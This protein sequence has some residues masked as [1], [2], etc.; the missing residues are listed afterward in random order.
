MRQ[1]ALLVLLCWACD[2]G[3]SGD[4]GLDG[5]ATDGAGGA[6]DG[7]MDR[8]LDA[9]G[10]E[11]GNGGE[12][13]KDA[14]LTDER[15]PD[16]QA[17]AQI[18]VDAAEGPDPRLADPTAAA[19]ADLAAQSARPLEISARGGL[20]RVV[21]LD[22][23]APPLNEPMEAALQFLNDHLDIWQVGDA[24]E[25][26]Y[27][28]RDVPHGDGGHTFSFGQRIDNVPVHLAQIMVDIKDGRI[29]SVQGGWTPN[30]VGGEVPVISA[31]QAVE[32]VRGQGARQVPGQAQAVW[33]DPALLGLKGPVVRAWKIIAAEGNAWYRTI[34]DAGTGEVLLDE[35]LSQTAAPD[36]GE[37]FNAGNDTAQLCWAFNPRPRVWRQNRLG[38]FNPADPDQIFAETGVPLTLS[39]YFDQLGRNGWNDLGWMLGFYVHTDVAWSNA[40]WTPVCN[41]I[42][43]GD[44][45]ITS[46]IIAHEFTHGVVQA[47]AGLVYLGEPG[48]LNESYADIFAFA[49][50]GD[51]LLGEG[52]GF[53]NFCPGAPA[54]SLRSLQ[55]PPRCGQPDHMRAGASGDGIGF[56][57]IDLLDGDN[58]AVHT[59]SGIH[60]KAAFLIARGGNHGGLNIRGLGDQAMSLLFYR[61]LT[62]RLAFYS[63][64]QDAATLALDEA[65][66]MRTEGLRDMPA[67]GPCQVRNAFAS[68][69]LAA[70][71]A[72]CDGTLDANEAD[73]DNDGVRTSMDNCPSFPNPGQGDV[74]G[75]GLGDPCDPDAD[76]D[77]VRN[78]R[79][80]CPRVSD[81]AQTDTD[82]N[83]L[84][85]ACQDTDRDGTV[86][87]V[88]NC[89]MNA[90][91]SQADLDGDS[92]GDAC[93][94]DRDGDGQ[95]NQSDTCPDLVNVSNADRDRDGDGD[96][97]DNCPFDANP[98]Q[99]DLDRDGLGDVCDADRD[100]DGEPNAADICPDDARY[101]TVD[102]PD[103][104]DNDDDGVPF[105]CDADEQDALGRALDELRGHLH[106][107][108][109]EALRLPLPIC[110]GPCP[111]VLGPDARIRLFLDAPDGTGF[112]IVDETGQVMG[113]PTEGPRFQHGNLQSIE[114]QVPT[115]LH[116]RAPIDNGVNRTFQGRALFLELLPPEALLG[117][118]MF[119]EMRSET[120]GF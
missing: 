11:G 64:L 97:C 10:G 91:R 103:F 29:R 35:A 77:G 33:Y 120:A 15:V 47:T 83:G 48:A 28:L 84:G 13:P 70:S 56:R 12:G 22:V 16:A 17:D 7:G 115:D 45:R 42:E 111:D 32:R 23:P 46:D 50:T 31:E 117:E 92:R 74:D 96:S 94:P 100:G 34:V 78:L 95:L 51:E 81:P 38:P 57:P 112:R 6:A 87:L 39:W 119:F 90:N 53:P 59:N 104:V 73:A 110:G 44:A 55:D 36:V 76:N 21:L 63:G 58:G 93:D 52:S 80:V 3:S 27:L 69:G 61:V 88:D 49:I 86:D 72:D 99:R 102:L 30:P 113:S 25:G 54:G 19:L 26:L 60:N 8:G 82:G 1:I 14:A 75:D 89:P 43:F 41:V 24:L 106:V 118:E 65:V 101:Q 68:V 40:H 114:I 37:I 71:D 67:D 98:D 4:G 105:L 18:S 20:P 85:D 108:R 2:S 79:D 116:Y 66:R 109:R 107:T 9:A 5:G 62:R